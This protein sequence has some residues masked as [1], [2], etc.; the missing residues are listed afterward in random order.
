MN[1]RYSAIVPGTMI[2]DSAGLY[3]ILSRPDYRDRV[4]VAVIGQSS[5]QICSLSA[6]CCIIDTLVYEA[7][8]ECRI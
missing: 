3:I 7:A 5:M 2:R 8:D 4:Y 1:V 6:D